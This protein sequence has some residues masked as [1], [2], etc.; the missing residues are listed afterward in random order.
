[1]SALQPGVSAGAVCTNRRTSGAGWGQAAGV[2]GVGGPVPWGCGRGRC[3]LRGRA[4]PH[5]GISGD[6]PSRCQ[7][8]VVVQKTVLAG[9]AGPGG[10]KQRSVRC[11]GLGVPRRSGRWGPPSEQNGATRTPNQ[12]T[13]RTRKP[14]WSHLLWGSSHEAS[15]VSP[16]TPQ[17]PR[18]ASAGDAG[19]WGPT[20]CLHRRQAPET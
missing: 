3:V 8:L 4:A 14:S 1:M 17:G 12:T 5:L 2:A 13:S 18:G 19:G 6:I 9:A 20:R 7:L 15:G 16:P 11:S 10:E